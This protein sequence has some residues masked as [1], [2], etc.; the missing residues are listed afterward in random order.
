MARQKLMFALEDNLE[1]EEVDSVEAAETEAALAEA[2]SDSVEAEF[3]EDSSQV[4]E[5]IEDTETLSKVED[6][7]EESIEEGE[8]LTEDA[9][10]IAEIAVESICN[11]LG[12]VPA[13]RIM[14]A[15][16]SFGRT[17]TRL[18]STKIALEG[19]KDALKNI[20][21]AIINRAKMIVDKIKE[22]I[23]SIF[24]SRK[25]MLKLAKTY[26]S[27]LDEMEADELTGDEVEI[28]VPDIDDIKYKD[29]AVDFSGVKS[30]V[31][32]KLNEGEN[33][34]IVGNTYVDT[35]QTMFKDGKISKE[36]LKE[37][38]IEDKIESA[39]GK[40]AAIGKTRQVSYTKT[41]TLEYDEPTKKLSVSFATIPYK[42]IKVKA[43]KVKELQ[44]LVK[45]VVSNLDKLNSKK[46]NEDL[47]SSIED[48]LK[49]MEKAKADSK[50]DETT[51]RYKDAI[52]Y[53]GYAL[54]VG[55]TITGNSLDKLVIKDCSD[56]LKVVNKSIKAK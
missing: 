46:N 7:M 35:I 48:I 27:E 21:D 28:K 54:S 23:S 19:V 24:D 32:S 56:L 31:E 43:L 29:K 25:K 30:T 52:K 53:A 20:W 16:E 3:N 10:E 47:S 40:A 34:I 39:V 55:N 12:Y 13:K 5:A 9:A 6:K 36:D 22:V 2:E 41:I 42:T 51:A 26:D 17:G 49:T 4:E 45:E 15:T 11:R 44:E 37:K 8:G 14:P 38:A 33:S 1:N 18:D 50:N